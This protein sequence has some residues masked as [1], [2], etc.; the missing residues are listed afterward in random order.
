LAGN[1]LDHG[2]AAGKQRE[3]GQRQDQPALF[4]LQHG[5]MLGT[6]MS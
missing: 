4:I 2:I 6:W 3:T 1:R 5:V